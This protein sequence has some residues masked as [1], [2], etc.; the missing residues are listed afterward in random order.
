VFAAA[1]PAAASRPLIVNDAS[2][3]GGVAIAIRGTLRA[4]VMAIGAET[5]G[6]TI[7]AGGKS[8]EL[9]LAPRDQAR[10]ARLDGKTATVYG[11]LRYQTGVEIARRAIVRVKTIS[12]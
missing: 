10:I 11:T 5:T 12:R 8:W 1:L 2:Q 7:T 3:S 4:G 6:V 9:E